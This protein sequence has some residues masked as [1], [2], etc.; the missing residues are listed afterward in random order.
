MQLKQMMPKYG[1]RI[2]M[3][4]FLAV[5]KLCLAQ[6]TDARV[7]ST[8]MV[9][10]AIVDK[11]LNQLQDS[12]KPKMDK[13]LV[14]GVQGVIGDYVILNSDITKQ[15]LNLSSRARTELNITRCQ[16]MESIIREK[17]YAHHAVQDSII[18]TDDQVESQTEQQIQ[19]ITAR[20]GGEEKLLELY[21]MESMSQVRTELNR[22]NRDRILAERME[23]A[24]TAE[25]EITPEE[26]R[27]FFVSL[28]EDEIPMFN[29][30]VE[31]AQI[32]LKPE[33]SEEAVAEVK[34]R[35]NKFREDILNGASFRTKAILYSDDV[36]SGRDGGR[37]TLRRESPF[38]KEF[39]DVA[40]SLDEGEISKPFETQFGWHILKV[41]KIRGQ[42]RDVSHI[43]LFPFISTEQVE[44]TRN[45]LEQVRD[46]IVLGQLEFGDAAR[47]ISD[48]EET[49][50]SGGKLINPRT[51]APRID[52]SKSDPE[53]V[54]NVQLLDEGDISE[55][56]EAKDPLQRKYFKLIYLIDKID[57][58]KAD[59]ATDFL[60]IKELAL[61]DKKV[62]VIEEWQNKKLSDTYVKIGSEFED[63][64]FLFDWTK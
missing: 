14:D 15:E 52:L 25:V 53:L 26:V 44:K 18:V 56:I 58:H 49:A 11:T 5:G 34:K 28:E 7:D 35:L 57:D 22:L 40:F 41:D 50:K 51:G 12:V 13:I 8:A 47:R 29:T 60:K 42:V 36:E 62:K 3:V 2:L 4:A 39:K 59:Y 17:M 20:V 32:V 23:Q 6:N 38:V 63:C 37:L 48:E 27:Q 64:E 19:G 21:N 31:V 9:D 55:I 43:L 61:S 33:P 45:R 54:K 1:F 46:S 30:E 16:L 24:I 10:K